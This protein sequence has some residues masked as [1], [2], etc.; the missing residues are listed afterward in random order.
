[1]AKYYGLGDDEPREDSERIVAA[2]LRHLP[3]GYVVF[4]HVTWQSKRK[5]REGDGEADFIVLH[6]EIGIIVFEVKGGGV[7]LVDGRW[8]STDRHNEVHSIKNPYDQAVASKHALHKWLEKDAAL[9]RVPV[10]HAVVFPHIDEMPHLGL[11]AVPEITWTKSDLLTPLENIK[12][13]AQH[14]KMKCSLSSEEI[15]RICSLLAPTVSVRRALFRSSTV[16]SEALLHL[17]ADQIEAFSGLRSSRG[18]LILGGAGTGK[19][20]LAL[21]RAQQLA[22]DGFRTIFVCFNELLG[23]SLSQ[24]FAEHPS[25]VAGTYHSL[26]FRQARR[27]KLQIPNQ[28]TSSWWSTD[29]PE[30]LVSACAESGVEFDAI[31]VDEAQDFEPSWI[32]SLRCLMSNRS[33]APFYAFADPRQ[34]LYGREWLSEEK[35]PFQYALSKNL[36]NTEPIAKRVLAIFNERDISHKIGGPAPMWRDIRDVK[37]PDIDAMAVVERLVEDGFGPSNLAVL[38]SSPALV[39]RLRQA[40]VGAFSFGKWGSRGIPVETIGRFKGLEAEAAVVVL[41]EQG[42][43][44]FQKTLAYVGISRARSV[45]VVVA[46]SR[47]RSALNWG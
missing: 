23:S 24:Q 28:L 8:Y 13:I 7:H 27:A 30:L 4:H 6:P 31:V 42:D 15:T 19:T 44:D 20:V 32:E 26:C 9:A 34:E 21:A 3:D 36:R 41:E 5:G 25:L 2:R 14:W 12:R 1:M 47:L 37:R 17:T 16:A 11:S 22:A 38:C 43:E 39:E 18:G 46:N 35:W 45:L 33:D 29:A 40:T 10:G